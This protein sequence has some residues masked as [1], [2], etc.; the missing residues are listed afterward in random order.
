M[1]NLQIRQL[2][3]GQ[4]RVGFFADN[5]ADFP[6]ASPGGMTA[7]RMSEV[8]AL[9]QEHAATQSS[10]EVS[11]NVAVKD[12]RLY[13]MK[14]ILRKMNRAANS[15]GEEIEG[16]EDLFRLPRKQ[17]EE[18]W[19]AAARAFYR[20]SAAYEEAF[21]DF[22]LPVTF[23]ADLLSLINSVDAA[24]TDT[25]ISESER[26]GATGA[27]KAYFRELGKLGRRANNIVLNKYEDDPEKLAAWDIASHLKAASKH[28]A[29][30]DEP[31]TE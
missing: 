5:A 2:N 22:D 29:D 19:L 21:F 17:S 8:I 26:G 25:D 1:N 27:L 28:D 7:A 4:S 20:D 30:E 16:I 13:E 12:E 15:L 18:S 31:P 14:R 6:P 3:R 11:R 10:G 9:I 24:S 23:R